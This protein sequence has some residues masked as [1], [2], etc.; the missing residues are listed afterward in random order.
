MSV[1]IV[2]LSS[3]LSA[4]VLAASAFCL[5][6]AAL[7]GNPGQN[8]NS[9]TTTMENTNTAKP[10]R[11]RGRR[12]KRR[13]AASTAETPAMPAAADTTAMPASA[14]EQTDLSGTYT[15]AFDCPDAGETGET[16]LTITGNQY[17][18][19]DGKSGRIVAATTRGYT[20]VA[21][22]FG[23]F[24]PA[25]PKSP[26]NTPTII[27]MRAKKSG[28]RLTLTTVP[29]ATRVCSF[30]PGGA[31]RSARTRHRR[32]R[33]AAPAT[34]AEPATPAEP[35][36]ATPAEP[37]TPAAPASRRRGRRGRRTNTNTNTNMNDNTGTGSEAAPTP[38]PAIPRN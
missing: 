27:S 28:D 35:A 23:E 36:M 12:H 11:G 26:G 8:A 15:G 24:T 6:S 14:T 2:R 22:Q 38:T 25:T 1:K 32:G 29:G 34:S 31:A 21:M 17:T 20:A 13:A 4:F 30:T 9:S 37:A 19:S 33:A 5:D 10:S 18:L 16:T 7:T 3:L